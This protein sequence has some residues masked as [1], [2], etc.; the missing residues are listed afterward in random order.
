MHDFMIKTDDH[1]NKHIYIDGKELHGITS[2]DI[3]LRVNEIPEITLQMVADPK[4]LHIS[5][6]NV[7]AQT[8]MGI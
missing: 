6:A 5:G 7:S 8:T 2:I 3:S 4:E 1:H